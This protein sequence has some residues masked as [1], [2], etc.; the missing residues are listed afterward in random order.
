MSANESGS[1]GEDYSWVDDISIFGEE[2]RN[3]E[4]IE[5]YIVY[6]YQHLDTLAFMRDAKE[7]LAKC[8]QRDQILAHVRKRLSRAGWEGDGIIQVLWFPPFL[9]AGVED[10]HGI[11]VW[12]VKQS[13]NG[14]SWLASPV[15]LPF[16]RLLE[17]ND[18]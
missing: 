9:G 10:T 12:H 2:L 7:V 8:H 3:P 13:N 5:N 16:D 14:T 17:Q 1:G 6:Q 18:P 11:G 4:V 15:S